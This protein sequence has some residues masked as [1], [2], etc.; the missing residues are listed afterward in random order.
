MYTSRRWRLAVACRPLFLSL[1]IV[2]GIG[3]PA[4]AADG[5][6]GGKV[7]DQLGAPI[8]GAAVTLLREGQ[9]VSDTTTDARGEFTFAAVPDGRYQVEASASGFE[10]RS[11]DALFVSGGRATLDLALQIGSVAQHVVVTAAAESVPEQHFQFERIGYFV[12]DRRDHRTDAP[13][14]NR[15]VTLRDTWSAKP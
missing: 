4:K 3:R 7:V 9:R 15:A 12:A 10:P 2:A 11:S 5:S 8:G 1:L 6:V 13:V 14:F